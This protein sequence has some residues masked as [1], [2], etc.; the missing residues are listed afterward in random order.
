MALLRH[1]VLGFRSLSRLFRNLHIAPDGFSLSD[2]M[3]RQDR[4]DR[5]SKLRTPFREEYRCHRSARDH[6]SFPGQLPSH[7]HADKAMWSQPLH[8][9]RRLSDLLYPRLFFRTKGV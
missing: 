3:L 7:A 6:M 8:F 9:V 5:R 4:Y 1:A 2:M